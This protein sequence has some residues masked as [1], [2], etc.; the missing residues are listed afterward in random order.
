MCWCRALILLIIS[1][2]ALAEQGDYLIAAG[3]DSDT[4]GSRAGTLIG[5]LATGD[6]TWLSLALARTDIDADQSVS[7]DTSYV[8]LELD[9]YF[10]PV[11]VR[12]GVSYWGD[13]E[14]LDSLDGTLSLYGRGSRFSIGGELEYRS[15][16][17]DI[18]PSRFFDGAVVDFDALG[19]G[20]NVRLDIAKNA[21]LFLS[22]IAYDYSI[23]LELDQNRPIAQLL[24]VSRLSLINSLIDYRAAVALGI[25]QKLSRWTFDVAT[26]RGA[27][28]QSRTY[29][30]SL[31]FLTPV[32]DR[33]DIELGLG[34][35]DSEL[36]GEVT[37]FSI[38]LY[39]YG[40]K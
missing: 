38:F 37:V 14:V 29:S 20:G 26:W 16:E 35:D 19:L 33:L 24:S 5:D 3:L 13:D 30:T 12:V 6:N 27:V 23:D 17:F 39:F 40:V 21:S 11:G 8:N 36:Y 7:V 34:Y 22:G 15:F 2:P 31:R 32:S 1:A 28:D 25:D 9:H 18:P 4:A 10:N